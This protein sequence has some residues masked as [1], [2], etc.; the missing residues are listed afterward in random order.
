MARPR[1]SE[2]R[3]RQFNLSLTAREL[4]SIRQRAA[5]LGMRPAHFGR[6]VLLDPK[7][8]IVVTPQPGASTDR[9]VYGQLARLG[10]NLN[11]M[12]RHLH[13]TNDPLPPDLEPL[14]RDIR[15]II[16]RRLPR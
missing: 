10:N 12:V 9:L 7:S 15:R 6:A 16:E 11:Q 13:R 5:A 14:L 2:S 8:K 4:D 3:N 1:K